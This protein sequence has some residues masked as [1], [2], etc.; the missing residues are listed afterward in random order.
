M[1]NKKDQILKVAMQIFAECGYER[2]SVDNIA[3]KANVAKGTIYYY[4]KSK[5]EI[6]SC[7]IDDGIEKLLDMLKSKIDSV[8]SPSEKLKIFLENQFEYFAE[9]KNFCKV[10]FSEILINEKLS[11]SNIK[12]LRN[13]YLVYL[14][15]IIEEGCISGEFKSELDVDTLVSMLFL[16]SATSSLDWAIFKNQMPKKIFMNTIVKTLLEGIVTKH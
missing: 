4:F 7:L 9:Y 16:S 6:F 10:L 8:T 1:Q 13:T 3:I 12:K 5:E 14:Q 15:Q 2:A 11:A